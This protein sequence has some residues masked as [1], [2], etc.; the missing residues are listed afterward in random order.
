MTQV[1]CI[2]EMFFEKGMKFAEISRATGF[3]VKTIK[4]YVSKDNFN[5]PPP[6][7][8]PVRNSK[9]DPFK[10]EIDQWL[11]DDKN[12]RKKQRHT[13]QRVFDRL[14]EIYGHA[15]DC[16]YRLVADY[17]AMKKRELYS[18]DRQFYF[19]LQHI[20]GEAQVDFG[21]AE[22]LE[23]SGVKQN[24]HHLNVSFPHSNGGFTQLFRG[25]NQ[26][27]L[28]EGL[29]NIFE[30]IGG[31]PKRIWFDNPG[32]M[33]A[34]VLKNGERVLTDTFLHFKNH[35]G[36]TAAFCNVA[37]GHEKGSVENKVGYHR[38]NLLVPPPRVDNHQKFNRQ[39]LI[40]CDKDMDRPHYVKKDPIGHLF[41]EDLKNL[42]PLPAETFDCSEL[43]TIKTNSSAKFTLHNGMHTYSTAPKYAGTSLFA[44]LTAH[45]VIVLNNNYHEVVRH[46]R[47]YGDKPLQSMDWLPYLTQ[48]S[49]RPA[50]LKYSGIYEL[51]PEEVKTFLD[52]LST[53]G[54]KEILTTLARLSQEAGFTS[55][56]TA[57]KV[58]VAHGT[59][60]VDSIIATFSRLNS[61]VLEIEPIGLAPEVPRMPPFASCINDYDRVFLKG[62][63]T[64]ETTNS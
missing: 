15:F 53:P 48:L 56:S 19:Q 40:K 45:E 22:F 64:V 43:V 52:S 44:R 18:G 39:L 32:T 36:F 21:E 57:L 2:R 11:E 3:D 23:Q 58:A 63:E 55:A 37:S 14:S 54:K 20:P 30:H 49:R 29:I 28:M 17:V 12:N 50:A 42:L 7:P 24:G 46:P 16:S 41:A 34:K 4:K 8:K 47:L 13:A 5:P 25:E 33:V 51:F 61:Q 59:E 31:V 62:G 27:C 60:D 26:Q 6:M 1:N 9:L 38:R 10:E 35:Y